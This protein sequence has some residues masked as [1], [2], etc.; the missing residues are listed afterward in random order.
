MIRSIYLTILLQF[1]GKAPLLLRKLK[2]L[3]LSMR[4]GPRRFW[5]IGRNEASIKVS[6]DNDSKEQQAAASR[7]GREDDYEDYYWLSGNSE[8]EE[9][10]FTSPDFIA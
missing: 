8:R 6:E 3:S 2:N 5:G 9:E 10:A 1:G 4:R 7:Q